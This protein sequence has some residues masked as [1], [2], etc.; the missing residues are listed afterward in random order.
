[1]H[2]HCSSAIPVPCVFGKVETKARLTPV[3]GI[4]VCGYG[5]RA[6]NSIRLIFYCR[7]Y[8]R[9]ASWIHKPHTWKQC[10]H[11]L[12]SSLFSHPHSDL[13]I[14]HHLLRNPLPHLISHL[15]LS[16]FLAGVL[17]R[18]GT[19]YK[20]LDINILEDLGRVVSTEMQYCGGSGMWIQNPFVV[21]CFSQCKVR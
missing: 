8:C 10:W 14:Y 4:S 1:M 3:L 5:Y 6:K 18:L 9:G 16:F 2:P 12:H 17:G 13:H 11:C 21:M 19:F 7:G 15:F 20:P